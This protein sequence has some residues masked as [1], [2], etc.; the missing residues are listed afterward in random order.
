VIFGWIIPSFLKT[1]E[2]LPLKNID[3]TSVQGKKKKLDENR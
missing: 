1:A 2:Y 3:F